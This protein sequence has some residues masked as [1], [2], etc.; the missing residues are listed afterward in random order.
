MLFID[1]NNFTS[2]L[3]VVELLSASTLL[4]LDIFSDLIDD[5]G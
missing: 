3:L 4:I 1:L 2:L 5:L